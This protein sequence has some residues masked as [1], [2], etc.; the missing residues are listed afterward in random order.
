MLKIM[1][2]FHANFETFITDPKVITDPNI[3]S[4]TVL[5]ENL[6]VAKSTEN[7]SWQLG[8]HFS[9]NV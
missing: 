7:L 8:P 1:E 3:L 4:I 2:T 5:Q 6:A 9:P